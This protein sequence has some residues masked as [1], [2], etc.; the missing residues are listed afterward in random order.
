MLPVILAL[1]AGAYLHKRCPKAT[2][3]ILRGGVRALKWSAGKA[4]DAVMK[5]TDHSAP[6]QVDAPEFKQFRT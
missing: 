4:H 3:A 6:K 2:E 1:G 5:A